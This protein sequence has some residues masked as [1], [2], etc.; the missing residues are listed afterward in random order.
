MYPPCYLFLEGREKRNRKHPT[1]KV[2]PL[3]SFFCLALAHPLISLSRLGYFF[4]PHLNFVAIKDLSSYIYLSLISWLLL[5]SSYLLDKCLPPHTRHTHTHPPLPPIPLYPSFPPAPSCI[6]FHSFILPSTYV[7]TCA[8]N[9]LLGN[10]PGA[11]TAPIKGEEGGCPFFAQVASHSS[12][13]L[14]S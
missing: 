1:E 9:P 2:P 7:I 4:L 12:K 6:S 14:C 10:V 3:A 11:N 5:S 8:L 13:A